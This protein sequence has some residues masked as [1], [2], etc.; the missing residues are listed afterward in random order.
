MLSRKIIKKFV[1]LTALL[2]MLIIAIPATGFLLLKNENVQNYCLNRI[3]MSLSE[4]TGATMAIGNINLTFFYRMRLNDVYIADNAGDTLIF[5]KTLTTGIRSLNISKK[6]VTLGSINLDKAVVALSVDSSYMLNLKN[7]LSKLNGKGGSGKDTW[8]INL[9]NIRLRNS[10]FTFKHFYGKQVDFGVNYTNMVLSDINADLKRFSPKKDSLSFQIKAL[11]FREQSGFVLE[12]LK[13][14]FS[15]SQ[16]FMSFRNIAILTPNSN[17]KGDEITFRF[18]DWSKFK[19]DTFVNEVKLK[20]NLGN[21]SVNLKDI[22]YFVP[23]FY[24]TNQQMYLS[25]QV[26]GPISNLKAKEAKVSFGMRSRLSGD[27]RIEGLPNIRET[28]I[29]ADFKEMTFTA[30]DINAFNVP[31]SKNIKLPQ[32]FEKLGLISFKGNFT[33]FINDFVTYGKF[34]T[35]LGII[36]TDLLLRPDTSDY[37]DFEGKLDAQS[38]DLNPL[39]KTSTNLGKISLSASING[40]TLAGKTF[41]AALNVLVKKLEFRNYGYTNILLAGNIENKTFDGSVNIHDP[42]IEFEF[43]GKVNMT[44]SIPAFDF[45]ANI[46][47]ANFY[48]LN[49]SKSDPDLLVSCY[50]IANAKGNSVNTLNGEVKLLNSLFVKKNKQLQVYDMAVIAENTAGN[51]LLRLQSD[52]VDAELSGNYKLSTMKESLKYF[53]CTYLPSLGDSI[54]QEIVKPEDSYNLKANIK[55]ARPLFDFFMP[56]FG[57]AENSLIN[58]NY[59]PY[60]HVALITLQ[61]NWLKVKTLSWNNLNLIIRG[62]QDYLN[63]EAGGSNLTLGDRI[64]LDNFTVI[65]KSGEDST[66]ILLRW[67]N[68]KDLAY[69][70]SIEAVASLSRGKNNNSPY[71]DISLLPTTI[72]TNDTVWRIQPGRIILDT[73]SFSFNNLAVNHNDEYFRINGSLSENPKDALDF[74]FYRFNLANLNGITSPSGYELQGIL[75]G[76][77]SI[78]NTFSNTLFTSLLKI[79]SLVINN[80]MLGN[81]EINSKWDDSRK[82]INIDGHVIRDNLKAVNITGEYIPAEQ[83]KLDFNIELD[84][85]RLNILNPYVKNIFGDLRGLATGSATLSGTAAKPLLNGE[86]NLQKTTFT[87]NYLQ[88]RY[89]FTDKVQ[90]ENN[91]IYF[92]NIRIYDYPKGNSAYLTGAIRNRYLK[93]FNIDLTIKSDE[94]LCMNTKESDNNL[95]YG[96]AYANDL[97]MKIYGPPRKIVMDIKAATAPNT[98]ISFPLTNEGKL[99]EY[100]FITIHDR[101]VE[102]ENEPEKTDYKVDLSGMQINFDL[103][104]TPDAEVQIVFDP[105]LGDKIK[106]RGTGNLDMK[107]NTAGNFLMFGE[108][109]IDKGN[110][111]FTLQNFINRDLTIESGGSIKWNGDPFD[112]TVN[113]VAYYRTKASLNDLYGTEDEVNTK[114]WVDDRITMTN[115]LMKPD[116]KYDIYLPDADESTRMRLNSAIASSDE[117]NKQFISLLTLNRFVPST[118]RTGQAAANASS[119]PYSS[120]A[121]V[122]ASEFLSN[123]LSHWLS[124]ISKDVDVNINYRSDRELKSDEVQLALSTQL[125][126]NRLTVNG[127]VDVTTT[128]AA[129]SASDNIVGEFDIDYKLTSNGKLRIKTFNHINNDMLYESSTYTQGLGFLYKEEFNNLGELWRRYMKA[130]GKKEEE[131]ESVASDEKDTTVNK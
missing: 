66:N 62:D 97:T 31:G 67:N 69:R 128:N 17:I 109:F 114:I 34:Q 111:L 59:Q 48:T 126:N 129:V 57:I 33:G 18:E 12:N 60:N 52:F 26:S 83:G 22:G 39:F 51:N 55:N 101:N 1:Q 7:F 108:Y 105:K 124:Q 82:A 65:S 72:T 78:S 10:R 42:N 130:L 100:Q 16:T 15:Q 30:D 46:T 93:D 116:V 92:K 71:V 121:G 23:V 14:D 77:A 131:P 4:K 38:F 106:G 20:I 117:L 122:N 91:N 5:V 102:K 85:L 61:S 127:S 29:L 104:V 53:I 35:D 87:I 86:F 32:I 40:S 90:I 74:I 73:T 110:Y 41:D 50:L 24:N 44:D 68:W 36:N 107:I 123:Q 27:I 120:A 84:K 96:T 70:G 58:L 9:N 99:D 76:N 11:H 28:F 63:F 8:T 64:K 119:N 2:L 13:G 80:E 47:D 112:A 37:I 89:N 81:A 88:T 6:E 49:F 79:D 113:I 19:S 103:T 125:F 43:L 118:S 54:N 21:S 95:F 56:D 3:I 98:V 45:T 115:K 75:N 94:F 25:A